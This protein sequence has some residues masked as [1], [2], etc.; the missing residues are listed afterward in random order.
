M[1]LTMQEMCETIERAGFVKKKD[2]TLL[3]AREIFEYSPTGELVMIWEWYA[4][5]K[6]MEGGLPVNWGTEIV[7]PQQQK[8]NEEQ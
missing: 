2:G 7:P 6:Q 4:L 8:K 1:S 3:T 5:A